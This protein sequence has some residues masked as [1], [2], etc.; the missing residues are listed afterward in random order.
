[1]VCSP[2]WL[3]RTGL[4]HFPLV[5]CGDGSGDLLISVGNIRYEVWLQNQDKFVTIVLIYRVNRIH[6]EHRLRLARYELH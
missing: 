5:N 1:M 4:S 3:L 6:I 2:T